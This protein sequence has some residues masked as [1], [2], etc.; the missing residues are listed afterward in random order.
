MWKKQFLNKI[1][2]RG[3]IYY[4]NG[5]VHLDEVD[6][7]YISATVKSD[8]SRRKYHVEIEYYDEP[9][10]PM[11]WCDCPYAMEDEN[12]KHMAAVMYM[13]EARNLH[14]TNDGTA[15]VEKTVPLFEKQQDE[16][17]QFFDIPAIVQDVEFT[18]D[19]VEEA[20]KNVASGSVTLQDI[21]LNYYNYHY[22]SDHTQIAEVTGEYHGK[23]GHVYDVNF[24]MDKDDILTMSCTAPQCNCKYRKDSYFWREVPKKACSHVAALMLLMSKHQKTH[25]IGDATDYNG[26]MM[27]QSFRNLNV[28]K[29]NKL[30]NKNLVEKVD[31]QP[32]LIFD[33]DELHLSFK[34][35]LPITGSAIASV[36]VFQVPKSFHSP[37]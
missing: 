18:S 11:M 29:D 24:S 22:F 31:I 13:I 34:I 1:L 7:D 25:T 20:K 36:N 32:R 4:L 33:D 10:D 12:C 9:D 3:K 6:G 28:Q 30:Q 15:G 2:Q 17:Y 21:R 5:N 26:I 27:M 8:N 16:P 35:A 14:N 23:N 19:V 37:T